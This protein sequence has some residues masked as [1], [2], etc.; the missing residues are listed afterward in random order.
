LGQAPGIFNNDKIFAKGEILSLPDSIFFF[1]NQAQIGR[2]ENYTT[3]EKI[4]DNR[5]RLFYW[6]IDHKGIVDPSLSKYYLK[7]KVKDNSIKIWIGKKKK[8]YCWSLLNDKMGQMI[9]LTIKTNNL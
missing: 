5:F 3:L 8:V 9:L 1:E 6:E 4:K 7:I 2:F